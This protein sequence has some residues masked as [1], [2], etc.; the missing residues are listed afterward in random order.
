MIVIGAFSTPIIKSSSVTSKIVNPLLIILVFSSLSDV[1]VVSS[2]TI[3]LLDVS[4]VSSSTVSELTSVLISSARV[5]TFLIC[6]EAKI[7]TRIIRSIT[8]VKKNNY[9]HKQKTRAK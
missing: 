7:Q 2:S 9:A 1:S 4:V 5:F 8:M 6:P 3:S